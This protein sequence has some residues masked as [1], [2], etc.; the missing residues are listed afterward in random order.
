MHLNSLHH[1]FSEMLR[2]R[3]RTFPKKKTQRSLHHAEALTIFRKDVKLAANWVNQAF[4]D[5]SG[6]EPAQ[7]K[8]LFR[9]FYLKWTVF[10]PAFLAVLLGEREKEGE[11]LILGVQESQTRITCQP[12]TLSMK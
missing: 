5:L 10:E 3:K 6:L 9:N 11:D 1:Y 8:L 4:P 2:M 7:R 12:G